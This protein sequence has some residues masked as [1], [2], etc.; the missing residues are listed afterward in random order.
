MRDAA[1]P[2]AKAEASRGRGGGLLFLARAGSFA[3]P[4]TIRM[5]MLMLRCPCGAFFHLRNSPSIHVCRQCYA[6]SRENRPHNCPPRRRVP[7]VTIGEHNDPRIRKP[8]LFT[9][10]EPPPVGAE[11]RKVTLVPLADD[12]PNEAA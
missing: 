12:E 10:V 6:N 8:T 11:N 1:P 7:A 9:V 4:I 2:R 3:A 5:E